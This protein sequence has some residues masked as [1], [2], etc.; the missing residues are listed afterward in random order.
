MRHA[1]ILVGI[2]LLA[3]LA[4]T[5]CIFSNPIPPTQVKPP[6]TVSSDATLK[7]KE[8]ALKAAQEEVRRLKA[9]IRAD[10][11]I[12]LQHKLG[13]GMGV[14]SLLAIGFGA[15]AWF[16]PL[17][18]KVAIKGVAFCGALICVLGV[19][20][21]LVPYF[22]T[23]GIFVTMGLTLAAG[24]YLFIHTKKVHDILFHGAKI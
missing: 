10:K 8:A 7:E 19:L 17:F 22:G 12:S 5:G 3:G 2:C 23:I 4:G 11:D 15:A 18:R 1:K 13:W 16:L 21:K 14:M 6:T 9:E 24:V 20:M